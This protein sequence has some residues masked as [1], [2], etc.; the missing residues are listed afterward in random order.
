[1]L[2]YYASNAWSV[3]GGA[4]ANKQQS[5]LRFEVGLSLKYVGSLRMEPGPRVLHEFW[6]VM[7]HVKVK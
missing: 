6:H 1:M 2:P 4:D 3:E 5:T 7:A